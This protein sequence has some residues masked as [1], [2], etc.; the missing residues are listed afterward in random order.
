MSKIKNNAKLQHPFE[1]EVIFLW[2]IT[3]FLSVMNRYLIET[4]RLS[5]EQF[6]FS[7]Q[8]LKWDSSSNAKGRH[9]IDAF[10][11]VYW[12]H[13]LRIDNHIKSTH[14]LEKLIEPETFRK[15]AIGEP[16][17]HNKWKDYRLGRHTPRNG[18]ISKA[19]NITASSKAIFE[20]VLWDTLR[21]NLPIEQYIE[22]W[23][24]RLTPEIQVLL[25]EH[26]KAS[27]TY[28]YRKRRKLGSQ[29]FDSIERQSGLAALAC[30]TV[31]IRE[32]HEN[33]DHEYAHE[34]GFRL[35]RML[36]LTGQDFYAHGIAQALYDFYELYI[37][38]LGIHKGFYYSYS[39][40]DFLYLVGR[41]SDALYHIEGISVYQMSNLERKQYEQRI[42]GWN[43]GFDYFEM[44][45]PAR[46]ALDSI[47][48]ES[49][50]FQQYLQAQTNVRDWAINAYYKERSIPYQERYV[51]DILE[52]E[53]QK[54][55]EAFES[56]DGF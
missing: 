23:L 36:L 4:N 8:A 24:S 6:C 38:P 18:L 1:Q 45:K 56:K 54:S 22:Q 16:Y 13:K 7:A 32:A 53:L 9:I 26:R 51:P 43:Y 20:H 47:V 15:S 30:L 31:L 21:L 50:E 10:R 29:A 5:L 42:L 55:Q 17:R 33:G 37:L 12:F 52:Q 2:K 48:R 49:N 35:C 19:E 39:N 27:Q 41:L 34:L 44:F 28:E 11:T 14:A 40:A 25:F 46:I 3:H